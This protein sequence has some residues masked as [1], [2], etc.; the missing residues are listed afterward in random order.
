MNSPNHFC[1][2][3]KICNFLSNLLKEYL[4]N[5]DVVKSDEYLDIS[6][7]GKAISDTA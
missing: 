6:K 1:L 2:L 4:D 5:S 7:K 3:L